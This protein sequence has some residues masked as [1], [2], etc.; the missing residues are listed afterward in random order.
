MYQGSRVYRSTG[1]AELGKP[2]PIL[3][4]F[5]LTSVST[6]KVAGGGHVYMISFTCSAVGWLEAGVMRETELRV[7]PPASQPGLAH[8]AGLQV[9]AL[10][11]RL[12]SGAP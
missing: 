9:E 1:S 7:S 4:R 5:A 2:Q 10:K 6:D 11:L 8:M 3:T 12:G